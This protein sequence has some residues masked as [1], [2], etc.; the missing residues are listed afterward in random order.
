M[1]FT[2]VQAQKTR[3]GRKDYGTESYASRKAWS[4]HRA[5]REN[6]RSPTPEDS[7]KVTGSRFVPRGLP[8]SCGI[9]AILRAET[10]ASASLQV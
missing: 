4:V 1:I 8:E 9:L 3:Q 5:L 6:A 10:M 7:P 2:L